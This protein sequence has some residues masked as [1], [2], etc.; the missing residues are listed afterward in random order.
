MNIAETIIAN[1]GKIWEKADIKRIYMTCEV[2]NKVTGRDYNLNDNSNK[3]FYDY[4][5]NAI[6]RS[7][8][9]KKA[10]IE[11]QF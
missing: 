9:G 10:T 6:M 3:I 5:T 8:K 4:S 1:S 11:V 2:F 7:Y